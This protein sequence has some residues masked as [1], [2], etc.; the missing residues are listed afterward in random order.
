MKLGRMRDYI[1]FLVFT[2]AFLLMSF[3][4]LLPGCSKKAPEDKMRAEY[5]A[6]KDNGEN[7]EAVYAPVKEKILKSIQENYESAGLKIVSIELTSK[8]NNLARIDLSFAG[9][10]ESQTILAG[11]HILRDNFPKLTSYAVM[12]GGKEI[13]ALPDNLAYI[14]S[15]GYNF[16]CNADDAER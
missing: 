3:M 16:D 9:H 2:L 1:P 10:S 14:E 5:T 4:M 15:I 13:S 7:E 6:S 8:P 12:R 11:L